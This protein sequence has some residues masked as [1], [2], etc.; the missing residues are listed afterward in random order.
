MP[1]SG[2]IPRL[3]GVARRMGPSPPFPISQKGGIRTRS[4]CRGGRTPSA[5]SSEVPGCR[6]SSG[7]MRASSTM[8]PEESKAAACEVRERASLE[9]ASTERDGDFRR[10]RQCEERERRVVVRQTYSDKFILF[11]EKKNACSY[12]RSYSGFF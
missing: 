1:R 8:R 2:G 5:R 10:S 7:A 4:R 6:S 3:P 11:D 9:L 12:V